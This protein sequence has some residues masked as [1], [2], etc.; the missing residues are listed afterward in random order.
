MRLSVRSLFLLV[1]A[2]GVQAALLTL[3][4]WQYHRYQQRTLAIAQAEEQP[5]TIIQGQFL[6]ANTVALDNQPNPAD[7]TQIGWRILTPFQTAGALIIVDRGWSRPLLANGVP[8]FTPFATSVTTISGILQPI[9]T[10]SGW[11]KG[12]ATTTHPQLLTLVSPSLIIS[13]TTAASLLAISTPT[14]GVAIPQPAPLANPIQNLSY[15]V[16]W[17]AMAAIFPILCFAAWKK[18]RAKGPRRRRR[19]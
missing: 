14:N 6:N 16:Q 7:P 3:A 13:Q 8:H 15:T 5:L 4:T 9:K 10:P 1:A 11:L 17:L 18:S 2:L 19:S 12:P